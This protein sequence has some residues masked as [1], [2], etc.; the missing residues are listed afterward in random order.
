[1]PVWRFSFSMVLPPAIIEEGDIVLMDCGCKVEGIVPMLPALLYLVPSQPKDNR[2]FEL[3]QNHRLQ[4]LQLPCWASAKQWMPPPAVI[5]DAGF[6]PI[7]NYPDCLTELVM[8]S[9][10]MVTNGAIW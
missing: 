6:A 5:I 4:D 1:M 3:E 8:V 2:R 9:V 10:W 7:I